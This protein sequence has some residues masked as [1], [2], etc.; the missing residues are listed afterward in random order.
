MCQAPNLTLHAE[1]R[2]WFSFLLTR[3]AGH[4]DPH[5]P[6]NGNVQKLTTEQHANTGVRRRKLPLQP[7]RRRLRKNAQKAG[8]GPNYRLPRL[9]GKAVILSE[10]DVPRQPPLLEWTR[11]GSVNVRVLNCK[12]MHRPEPR[13]GAAPELSC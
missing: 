9:V 11:L 4:A 3:V 13:A 8:N 6:T 7:A 12:G 2:S 10:H 5:Y 1:F